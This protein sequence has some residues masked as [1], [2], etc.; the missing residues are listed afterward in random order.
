MIYFGPLHEAPAYFASIGFPLPQNCNPADF[1]LD[2]SQ[3]AVPRV[4]H[5]DHE[6]P[7]LFDL[8][9]EH[10]NKGKNTRT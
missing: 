1:Y 3:G 10:K 7:K 2:V 4:G 8:W 9:E 5:P 6:W